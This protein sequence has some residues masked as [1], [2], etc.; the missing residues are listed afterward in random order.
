MDATSF[1]V[2]RG[3]LRK[4]RWD[5][6]PV[7]DMAPG[8]VIVEVTR[9]GLTANNITYAKYG[10][11]V[12]Y[13]QFFPTPLPWG[14]IPVWATGR[15]AASRNAELPEGENVY[16]YFPMASHLKLTPSGIKPVRFI[17]GAAHRAALPGTYNEYARIDHAPD[18]S[19]AHADQHL[20]LRPLFALAFFL[21]AHL[22][23]ADF[24]GAK[25]VIL[26][27]ASAKTAIATALLLGSHRPGIEVVGL[28]SPR[29]IALVAKTGHYDAI[30]PYAEIASLPTDVPTVVVDI[31]GDGAV[32]STIHHH[33]SDSIKR[34]ILVGATHWSADDK[35]EALPGPAPEFFFTPSHIVERRKAWG[36]PLLT[37]RLGEAWG[38]MLADSPRWLTIE[39]HAGPAAIERIYQAVLAG[40]VTPDVAPILSFA[41]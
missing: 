29:S 2:D 9:F 15:I 40:Q 34:S 35:A 33:L 8:E 5:T 16:G 24:F 36:V 12:Q 38:S 19:P 17:D 14:Q 20:I 22:A 23:E 25:R 3:D 39:R 37:Q 18:Y 41:G 26:T 11:A 28:T 10:D 13:W 27:S 32:R 31:A 21:A 7:A 4:W 30:V 6:A 1:Q